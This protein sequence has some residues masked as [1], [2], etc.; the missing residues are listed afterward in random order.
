MSDQTEQTT[1]EAP[2]TGTDPVKTADDKRFTQAELDAIVKD[3]LDRAQRKA[4]ADQ[5]KAKADAEARALAEQGEFKTL[6]EQRQQRIAELENA[7]EQARATE[8]ERDRYKAAL[9]SHV[10]ALRTELPAHLTALLDKLD[11][12]DQLEWM[13][14]NHAELT[15]PTAPDINGGARGGSNGYTL[16]DDQRERIAKRYQSTF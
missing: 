7:H 13:S 6:A 10:Q 3:R 16:T 4:A 1:T 11:P 12:V 2:P 9:A 15:R 5:E 8:K 14:A